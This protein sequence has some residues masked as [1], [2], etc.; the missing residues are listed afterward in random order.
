M[1]NKI[2]IIIACI[3]SINCYSQ[4]RK[5][6]RA[7]KKYDKLAYIDAI[8]T[9]ESVAEKG[10]KSPDMLQKL[11]NAYYFNANLEKA[12]KWYG[13]LFELTQDV[14][15]EYYYRY[16]QSL[17]AIKE[18]SKADEMM[19]KFSQKK[20]NDLRGK[21][22]EAQKDYLAVI[23][24]N[25][26]R[27]TIENVGVNTKMSDYGS[28]F[29]GN[30][31]IFTS[32]KDTTRKH[33]WTN[34]GFTNLFS[35]D[36]GDQG[37][38]SN[39]DKFGNKLNSKYHEST[40][41]F[42]KDGKT[43]YFTRN[44]FLDGKTGKDLGKTTLLKV[45]RA[46]LDGEK[47]AN[48]TALPFN[49]DNYSIAHP[50]L[51]KDEKTLFF[52]S[53]M[54]GSLGQSDIFKVAINGDGS[55]G[56]PENL[57]KV[58]NTEGRETF[59]FVAS[60]N[61]LYFASDGHPGLGGLDVF[62]SQ[63]E[64]NGTYEEVMNVG[65]PV[66]TPKDDFCFIINNDT[67]L[68]YLSSNRDGGQGNDDIYKI[69][70]IKKLWCEQF[71]AGVVTDKDT[72][73]IV[74]NAKVTLLDAN[75][76]FL[77]ETTTDAEGKFD[78]G[79]VDCDTKFYIRTE[80]TEYTTVETPVITGKETGKTVV[81]I[82]IE[83]PIKQV[84]LGDDLGEKLKLNII[85]FDLDKS[86]IRKDAELELSK[87]LVVLEQNPTMIIDIR[88]HTDCRQTAKYN[89]GLS[90]RRA[91]ATMA[92]LIKN[93]IKKSRLTAKGYGESQLINNCPCEPTNQSNC[94]EEEHQANRRSEFVIVD[95]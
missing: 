12:A 64:E 41:V 14:E 44:N 71:L 42:T 25:S 50:A 47:W 52:A 38:L 48:I 89:F 26:G 85:Y 16:A 20:G 88:S 51:S 79:K 63:L 24:K 46:T 7:D 4:K 3:V 86:N 8:K 62:A 13:E 21:L 45:Y 95:L 39:A 83:K 19:A 22:A 72:G 91:K 23:K 49:N 33:A 29:F 35:A 56:T 70:E 53:N 5:I 6:A 11:G 36:M 65:E 18:Y 90:D 81:P 54:P 80:K 15:P 67:S 2:I 57:G 40:P 92:W 84:T 37:A 43:V 60:D 17:K 76:K 9:F 73:L 1:K 31:V 34:E 10:Y 94:S 28:A 59:P 78:F 66:N 93:G 55:F 61:E 82:A 32:A 74:A 75:F 68:G 30:K 27:Y 87:I 77:K 58:I 69:K